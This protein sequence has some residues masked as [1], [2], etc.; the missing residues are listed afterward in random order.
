MNRGQIAGSAPGD[1][2]AQVLWRRKRLASL[3]F[4]A[5]AGGVTIATALWPRTYR[6][7]AKLLVRLGRE[8]ATLDPTATFGKEPIVAVSSVRETEINSTVE[9]LS[10]RAL[11]E[12][13]VDAFGPAAILD[14]VPPVRTQGPE[15]NGEAATA[16]FALQAPRSINWM[17]WLQKVNLATRLDARERAIIHLSRNLRAQPVR[18][19]DVVVVTYDDGDPSVAQRVLAKLVDSYLQEHG[20]LNR[21]TGAHQFLAEQTSMLRQRMT[22]AEEELRKW[23]DKTGLTDAAAQREVMVKRTAR[24]EEELMQKNAAIAALE[25]RVRRTRELL[26][27]LPATEVTS[28]TSGVGNGGSD[29]MRQQFYG[30]Q[31]QEQAAAAKYTDEHPI[32]R[33]LREQ[34]AAAKRLF[35][36]EQRTRNETRTT[37]GRRYEQAQLTLLAD[38]PLLA[39]YQSEVSALRGQLAQLN[40]QLRTFNENDL[41]IAALQREVELSATSYRRYA[42]SMEQARIDQALQ[43]ERISNISVVQ[44]ATLEAK[45]VAPRVAW[46]LL[47]GLLAGL[48]GGVGVAL[49]VEYSARTARTPEDVEQKLEQKPETPVLAS[50]PRWASKEA[51]LSGKS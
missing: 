34:T 5:I 27:K 32:L 50:L 4:L 51:T 1:Q 36:E 7:E 9:I 10:T 8:N 26:D 6:S 14:G 19:S 25:T 15:A 40:G 29:L 31:V 2:F 43:N 17:G 41:R 47:S 46:N 3:V 20:R 42:E 30:L 13:V 49:A 44:P 21:T 35:D 23:K 11:I 22:K 45:P 38:E 48:A 33:E 39:S 12:K 24:I 18:K 16:A 37:P 28:E